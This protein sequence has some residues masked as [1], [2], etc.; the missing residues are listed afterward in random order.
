MGRFSL[1]SVLTATLCV[2]SS[3][4]AQTAA[5][6]PSR[7][8]SAAYTGTDDLSDV[9]PFLAWMT[10]A[11][12][13]EGIDIEP[14]TEF[15]NLDNA[16]GYFIGAQGAFWV[17]EGLEVGGRLGYTGFEPDGMD[18]R[19]G[20]SDLGVYGR[21]RLDLGS[22]SPDVAIGVL[23]TLPVGD[24]D[25]GQSNFDFLAFGAFR[26]EANE[27]ITLLGHA[28][29]DS[30]EIGNNRDLGI[31]LGG[32]AILPMTEELAVIVELALTTAVDFAAV[33]AGVDYELPPGGHLR[34]AVALG[35]DDA[36]PD[37]QLRLGFSVPVY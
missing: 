1:A 11:T 26:Y 23:A 32:G 10:D 31:E 27:G 33:V 9:R 8:S 5:T 4:T 35:I 22:D 7:T 15:S 20:L 36:A 2:A 14:V 13:S 12:W 18:S 37:A 21:Y 28:G 24:E 34:A 6:T 25:I 30:R 3:A 16:S 19:S 29:L 17:L